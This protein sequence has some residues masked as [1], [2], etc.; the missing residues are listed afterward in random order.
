M[1]LKIN[2]ATSG[3]VTLAAPT[4]GSDISLTLPTLGFGK[5]L[6]AVYGGTTTQVFNNTTSAVDTGVTATITPSSSLSRILVVATTAVYMADSACA[7]NIL[8]F[9]GGSQIGK[10]IVNDDTGA[11]HHSTSVI[12]LIDS[13]STTS[14]LIYKTTFQ[15]GTAGKSAY[16]S[17]ASCLSSI[18][19]LEVGP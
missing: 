7:V 1:P 4:T 3:S 9:R 19:L 17:N 11:N 8:L 14:S 10:S 15:V 16:V 5:V 6:Q 18:I 12:S 2:G 13:P